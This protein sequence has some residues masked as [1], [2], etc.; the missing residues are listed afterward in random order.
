MKVIGY[1]SGKA[2]W[3]MQ[4]EEWR[5]LGGANLVRSVSQLTERFSFREP[6]NLAK[7]SA[8]LASGP[9]S[10]RDG[11]ALRDKDRVQ[12]RSL[13]IY[14]DT[15]VADAYDTRSAEW[16]LE[17]MLTW[18]VSNLDFRHPA[19]SPNKQYSSQIVIEFDTDIDTLLSH[20]DGISKLLHSHLDDLYK[21]SESPKLNRL[22]LSCDS[23]NLPKTMISTDFLLERRVNHPYSEN[24]FWCQGAFHTDQLVQIAESLE[25]MVLA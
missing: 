19:R 18:A 24:R 8:E 23:T 2:Y 12:I 9:I 7:S 5:P 17:E 16:F 20:F 1:E 11:E 13:D 15:I 25:Q 4:P 14:T 3:L 6:P 21:I 10:F 22:V